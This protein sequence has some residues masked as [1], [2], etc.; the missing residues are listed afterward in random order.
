LGA[1]ASSG[2]RFEAYWFRT[3]DQYELNLVLDFGKEI[4]AA[5]V[6]LTT[7][8]GSVDMER[9]NAATDMIGATRRFLI[10]KTGK[11]VGDERRASCNLQWLLDFFQSQPRA[12]S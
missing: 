6:K 1:A 3:S 4:W 5:E 12:R 9:L 2:I 8:P 11:A 7:S 10:S